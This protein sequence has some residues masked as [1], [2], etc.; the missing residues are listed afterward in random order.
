M[1]FLL[2]LTGRCDGLVVKEH[3][4]ACPLSTASSV[5]VRAFSDDVVLSHLSGISHANRM[6]LM[7]DYRNLKNDLL[8]LIIYT[9]SFPWSRSSEGKNWE[10]SSKLEFLTS[11]AH[12]KCLLEHLTPQPGSGKGSLL[13]SFR[14]N[15]PASVRVT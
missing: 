11:R 10:F 2:S 1:Y 9:N 8:L 12:A 5:R 15:S 6:I 14:D 3:T 7:I 13:P 4:R